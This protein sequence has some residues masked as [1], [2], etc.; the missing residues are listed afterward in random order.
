MN[1]T[2]TDPLA[3]CRVVGAGGSQFVALVPAGDRQ[4][5]SASAL[6]HF[7]ADLMAQNDR[8]HSPRKFEVFRTYGGGEAER[9]LL[10]GARPVFDDDLRYLVATAKRYGLVPA[11]REEAERITRHFEFE[12][13]IRQSEKL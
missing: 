12:E 4:E 1:E 3:D 11:G 8:G 13:H 5:W 6:K 9:T 2:T 7:T 10:I